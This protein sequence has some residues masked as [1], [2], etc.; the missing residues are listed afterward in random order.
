MKKYVFVLSMVLFSTILFICWAPKPAMAGPIEFNLVSY[1][2]KNS[3]IFETFE[4]QWIKKVNERAKGELIVKFRG[5]PE[6]IPIFNQAEAVA[7]GSVDMALNGAGFYGK[8]IPGADMFRIPDMPSAQWRKDGTIEYLREL[9]EAK[10]IYFSGPLP[11]DTKFLWITSRIPLRNREDMKGKRFA[12]SPAGLSFFK[13]MGAT[14][15][16]MAVSEYY[17]ALERG[18]VDGNWISI[19]SYVTSSLYEVAPY[20]IDH[21]FGNSTVDLIINLKK[22]TALPD[23]LKKLL[24]EVQLETEAN[25]PKLSAKAEAEYKG[26]ASSKG[27]KFIQWSPEDAKWLHDLYAEATWEFYGKL[28]GPE[29]T[30]KFKQIWGVK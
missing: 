12:C 5:G 9:H 3:W 24:N 25:W 7:K 22:W 30:Q 2:P 23:H 26:T 18:V 15:M 4:S 16:N 8:F 10:G 28:Y 6:T 17:T 21:P 20:L 13:Q 29:I 1:T 19:D 11:P 27:A 14:P